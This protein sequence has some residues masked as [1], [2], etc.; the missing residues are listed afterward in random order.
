MNN[1]LAGNLHFFCL[2][3]GYF[4]KSLSL[5]Q[6]A[7]THP[8]LTDKNYLNYQ[9][10]EFLSDKVL[11]IIIADF[12]IKKYPQDKEGDLSKKQAH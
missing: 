7:I 9:R 5:L 1:N 8:S 10:L 3:I 2:N 6:E 12:L 11:A 4:F